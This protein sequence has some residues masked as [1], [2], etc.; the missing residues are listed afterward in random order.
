MP[1]TATC[2]QCDVPFLY[3]GP[4]PKRIRYLSG[5]FTP[6]L[7]HA[8]TSLL[9]TAS[10]SKSMRML[11]IFIFAATLTV[12]ANSFSQ[13]VTLSAKGLSLKSIFSA[14][15]QQTGFVFFYNKQLLLNTK[16][17]TISAQNMPLVEFLQAALKDQPLNFRIESKTIFL[18]HKPVADVELQKEE[19]SP[20]DSIRVITG[21][22]M[23]E[24]GE[25]L[26]GASVLIKGLFR[27]TTTDAKGA[28]VI[29]AS[30]G[31]VLVISAVGHEQME[32]RVRVSDRLTVKMI[33]AVTTMKDQ[34]VTGI[35]QRKKES[36]TGSSTTFTAKELKMVSNQSPLQALKTLDPSFAIIEKSTFGS[37][38]NRLPD[39][40]IRG[41]SSVIGL[42]EQYGTNPNQPLFIRLYQWQLFCH[43]DNSNNHYI[44]KFYA[45][46][47]T[48]QKR[49]MYS[50]LPLATNFDKASFYAFSSNRTVVFYAVGNI[51]YAYDYNRGFEKTYTFPEVADEITML[52][53]DTQV[54]FTA[55]A[56]YV[57]TYN[58]STKGRLRRYTVGTNPNTVTISPVI[59]SDWDGLIKIKDMNWRAVN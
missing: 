26:V 43:Y 34:V 16:P 24:N 51:L 47:A 20:A 17:V 4:F 15:E 11:T 1:K 56:L 30:T 57:A 6:G 59:K 8:G 42:T 50:V 2:G 44:Y 28:F 41:K 53:F 55:N 48:P 23:S 36:F 7:L 13:E 45:N 3:A 32:V 5:K 46:G 22:V 52:K 31:Q 19:I 39:I 33:Q 27:G 40:E 18:S 54:D 35:Y 58:A 37:D 10:K 12:S 21:V 49:D 29:R 9:L 38:P 25:P 14:V